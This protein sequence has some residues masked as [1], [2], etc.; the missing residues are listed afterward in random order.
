MITF[1][2]K[3]G[4]IYT[5]FIDSPLLIKGTENRKILAER[6]IIRIKSQTTSEI[7]KNFTSKTGWQSLKFYIW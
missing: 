7:L 1:R 5:L 2:I 3:Y 6:E 4:S